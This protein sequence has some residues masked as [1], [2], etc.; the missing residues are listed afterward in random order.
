MPLPHKSYTICGGEEMAQLP[1]DVINTIY[2][3][4]YNSGYEDGYKAGL[5]YGADK[6]KEQQKRVAE[7]KELI[8]EM[9]DMEES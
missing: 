5:R 2:Q 8:G 4:G 6:L 1:N 7:I 9:M 3:D